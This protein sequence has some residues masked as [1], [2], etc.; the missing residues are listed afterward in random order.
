VGAAT[1]LLLA[2]A[3]AAA[4]LLRPAAETD[5]AEQPALVGA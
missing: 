1:G 4:L 2:A 5:G 3:I